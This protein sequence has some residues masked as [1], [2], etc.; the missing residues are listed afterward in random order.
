[1]SAGDLVLEG[2]NLTCRFGG[3]TAVK[4]VSFQLRRG[5]ILGLIGP[6]GA[7]KTTLISMISGT[8]HTSE[9]DTFLKGRRVTGMKPHKITHMGLARTFQVVKPFRGMTVKEN[10]SVGAL[11]GGKNNMTSAMRIAEES[12]EM[13]GLLE[14]ADASS[15][16]LSIGELK[17]LELAR[18]L[19]MKPEVLMLDE[20]MAGL[21]PSQVDKMME[22]VQ[23]INAQGM[24]VLIIDHVLKAVMG[25]SHRVMVLQYGVK[26]AE[27]SP[28]EV[29]NN[30]AVMSGYLG[31]RY[32]RR[33][34]A[35][36]LETQ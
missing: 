4:D 33:L 18:T 21:N 36:E 17:R 9:G 27:G 25:I 16:A 22:L 23:R 31:E 26:I 35:K 12:L 30:P 5:E 24:T 34:A 1:M 20:V 11:F 15:S 28:R 32:A 8:V 29:A 6:N 2:R 3:V 19:A 13:V 7:G 10:V 14:R